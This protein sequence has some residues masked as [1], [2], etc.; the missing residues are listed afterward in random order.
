MTIDKNKGNLRRKSYHLSQIDKSTRDEGAKKIRNSDQVQQ[1]ADLS[2]IDKL[3]SDKGARKIRNSD[4]VQQPAEK[5]L[6]L[7]LIVQLVKEQG[8]RSPD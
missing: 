2:Q 5:S 6:L 4:Q 7:A 1:P 3:T 8:A